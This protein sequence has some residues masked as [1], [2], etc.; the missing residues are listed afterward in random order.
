MYQE[1]LWKPIN[2]YGN[3]EV[4]NFGKV[5]NK[6]TK[7]ILR[8]YTKSGYSI[9]GLS[10]NGIIKSFSI[11]RLVG[12]LFIDNPDNKPEINHKDKNKNNNNINNLE[13]VTSKEN[14]IHKC[15]EIR[16]NK[17]KIMNN[18]NIKINKFDMCNNFLKTYNSIIDAA[19]D[20]FI[21]NNLT[22]NINSIRNGISRVINGKYKSSF[23]Y[24]WEIVNQNNY[25]NEI[26]KE[27]IINNK[28]TNYYV[29][30]LGRFK[31]YKGIIM[32]NYKPHYSG[33]IYVRI[34]KN[35]YSLHYLVAITFINNPENKKNIN[36]IDGNKINNSSNNLEWCTIKENNIHKY[37]I[38][39]VNK[40]VRKI[41]QY[42]LE[43]NKLKEFNSIKEAELELK[44]NTIKKVLYKKQKT[45]GGYIFKYLE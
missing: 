43:N 33:Y 38:N 24:R 12:L 10:K 17:K 4:S 21:N 42:D 26:W 8:E 39:L 18:Q 27:V 1:E 3:Y 34:N 5:R 35:K 41:A 45:A 40:Y 30:N 25:N 13:W 37:K 29:S 36:H 16:K 23:G 15:D 14:N 6:N 7:R 19:N 9:V 32:E 31:N 11:H 2:N 44:I 28:N 20:I 22:N